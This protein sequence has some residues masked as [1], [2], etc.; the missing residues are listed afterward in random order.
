MLEVQLAL[1]CDLFL[2]F[3]V[4]VH[5]KSCRGEHVHENSGPFVGFGFIIYLLV[6]LILAT[7]VLEESYR[8]SPVAWEG[9][10]F[11]SPSIVICC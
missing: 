5:V 1:P 2:T 8:S 3:P 6:C 10:P 7:V 4:R 11:P 9:S